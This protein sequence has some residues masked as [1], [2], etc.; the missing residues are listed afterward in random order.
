MKKPLNSLAKIDERNVL[1]VHYLIE[2]VDFLT[3]S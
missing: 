3:I 1:N 2:K